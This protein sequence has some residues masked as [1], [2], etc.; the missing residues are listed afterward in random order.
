MK[1]LPVGVDESCTWCHRPVFS[2]VVTLKVSLIP[3]MV[4]T[5]LVVVEEFADDI[6]RIRT[7]SPLTTVPA[8]VVQKPLALTSYSP[9]VTEIEAGAAMP[10]TEMLLEL[11]SVLREAPVWSVKLNGSGIV[12]TPASWVTV[13]VWPAIVRYPVRGTPSVFWM[14]V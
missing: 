3:P 14:T 2:I 11:I 1:L 5:A 13:K 4:S 9:L 7:E 8:P 12:S 6:R 10:D